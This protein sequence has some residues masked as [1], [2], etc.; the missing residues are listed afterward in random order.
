[1]AVVAALATWAAAAPAADPSYFAVTPDVTRNLIL[2]KEPAATGRRIGEIPAGTRGIENRGC[3]GAS[4][5]AWDHL[6]PELRDAMAKD[7]WCRVRW[8]AHEGWVSARF[9]QADTGPPPAP[10]VAAA[11]ATPGTLQ[12]SARNVPRSDAPF[13]GVEWRIAAIGNLELRDGTA[14]LKFTDQ[15]AMEG[16]TGCNVLRASFAAG[17]SALRIGPLTLT[18]QSCTDESL[19]RQERLFI[20]ALEATEAQQVTSGTLRLLDG[21][22]A[23]RALFRSRR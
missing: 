16:H 19:A 10:P 5:A 12:T 11:A 17:T 8:N 22:G 13:T 18:R 6:T 1:M 3:R 7:R 15:G 4:D 21:D 20:G 2:R 9:L 14:W 23:T